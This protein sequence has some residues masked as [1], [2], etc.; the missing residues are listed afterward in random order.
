LS[1]PDEKSGYLDPAIV[2]NL[3]TLEPGMD[4]FEIYTEVKL[5]NDSLIRAVP[6]YRK[7]GPWYDFVNVQYEEELLPARALCFYRK[8]EEEGV[9]VP[10][11]LVHGIDKKRE[12]EP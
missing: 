2:T 7:S 4:M 11:A 6:N 10:Y 12:D 5:R 9:D 8:K 1:I 3:L